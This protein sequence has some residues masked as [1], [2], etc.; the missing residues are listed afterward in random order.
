MKWEIST[1]YIKYP[2]AIKN[3]E[4]IVGDIIDNK[5]QNQGWILEHEHI[6]TSGTSAKKEELLNKKIPQ[7]K[8]NRGGKW[9]YHGP[10]QI[11]CYLMIDLNKYEKDIKKY[12]ATLEQIIINT[13]QDFNVQGFLKENH[14]GVWV[15]KHNG[16]EAKIAAIGVRVRKWVAYHGFSINL[17]PDLSMFENIIP[18]GINHLGVTSLADLQINVLK[19]D[20]V[21]SIIKCSE[22]L[23]R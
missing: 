17:N 13:L 9:T 4:N 12:V 18:C 20:L 16:E 11:V 5:S 22:D 7:I 15:K 2:T 14:I 1:K 23:L 10:G 8:T 6:F 3:M 21:Q 19:K